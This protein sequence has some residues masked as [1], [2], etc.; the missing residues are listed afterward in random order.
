MC[1]DPFVL[2]TIVRADTLAGKLS[3][4]SR[5]HTFGVFVGRPALVDTLS[6]HGR[7]VLRRVAGKR[8]PHHSAKRRWDDAGVQTATLSEAWSFGLEIGPLSSKIA[9]SEAENGKSRFSRF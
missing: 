9:A 2:R 3:L 1:G 4:V 6:Q 5:A 7:L 8:L